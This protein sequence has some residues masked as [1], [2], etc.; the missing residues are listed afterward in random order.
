MAKVGDKYIFHSS[1]GMDY[2]ITIIN[3][4]NFRDPSM[5]YGCDVYDVNGTHVGDV[6][7]FGEDFISKCKKVN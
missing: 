2:D 6:M 7:F 4:N 1:N 3:V 5:K